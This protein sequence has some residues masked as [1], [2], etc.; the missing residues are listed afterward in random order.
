[1]CY[2]K[3]TNDKEVTVEYEVYGYNNSVANAKFSLL[4]LL[5]YEPY[6]LCLSRLECRRP[7]LEPSQAIGTHRAL[8]RSPST[9]LCCH[10]SV[11]YMY[12]CFGLTLVLW[13]LRSLSLL[14][15]L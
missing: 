10:A 9:R 8:P 1:M 2:A 12:Y 14:Y 3:V 4:K 11:V 5:I 13:E 6:Y 7:R 15:I